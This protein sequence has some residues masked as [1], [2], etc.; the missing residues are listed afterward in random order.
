MNVK[1]RKRRRFLRLRGINAV[2]VNLYK[3][4]NVNLI[5]YLSSLFRFSVL[6][7]TCFIFCTCLCYIILQLWVNVLIFHLL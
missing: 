4:K 6:L 2:L 7:L 3:F 1:K 5:G